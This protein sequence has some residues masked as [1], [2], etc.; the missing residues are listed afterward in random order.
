MSA[1]CTVPHTRLKVAII[2]GLVSC[3][4]LVAA[5]DAEAPGLEFLEYLGSWE[6]SDEDW[7]LFAEKPEQQEALENV[8]DGSVPAPDGEKLAELDDEN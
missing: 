1:D 2:C 5:D 3:V 6:E 8:Q 4:G 7:V